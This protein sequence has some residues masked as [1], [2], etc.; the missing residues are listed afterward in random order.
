MIAAKLQNQRERAKDAYMEGLFELR[1]LKKRLSKIDGDL[2]VLNELLERQPTPIAVD[3]VLVQELVEVF[4]CWSDL[5]ISEKREL[6]DA[7]QI[8][9]A[10]SRPKRGK[11]SV[12]R[13]DI[14]VLDRVRLYKKLK[15]YGMQ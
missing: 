12:D 6:L 10:V 7:Y 2:A 8:R 3:P 11:V 15:R 14:G 5:K 13:V 4:T 9:I 1:E